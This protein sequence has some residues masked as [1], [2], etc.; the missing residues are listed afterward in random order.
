MER[1][2]LALPVLEKHILVASRAA[3]RTRTGSEGGVVERCLIRRSVG[4]RRWHLNALGEEVAFTAL[5]CFA[6]VYVQVR[7]ARL[8]RRRCLSRA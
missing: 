1:A 6:P 2:G 5:L 8:L 3:G 4:L 7:P